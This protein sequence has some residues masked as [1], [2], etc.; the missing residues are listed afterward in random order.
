[1]HYI[2]HL[3]EYVEILGEDKCEKLKNKN[4]IKALA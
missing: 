2:L 3:Y 4:Q 1:M